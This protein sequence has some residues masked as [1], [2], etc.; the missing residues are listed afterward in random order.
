MTDNVFFVHDG[1]TAELTDLLT[2]RYV[3]RR[4]AQLPDYQVACP[5]THY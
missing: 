4:H 2:V 3:I 5:R 1:V